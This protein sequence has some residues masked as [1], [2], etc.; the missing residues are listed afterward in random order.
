MN[1]LI[2]RTASFT[3]LLLLTG[4]L[5]AYAQASDCADAQRRFDAALAQQDFK[6]AIRVENEIKDSGSCG[7]QR[8]SF[9]AR[10]ASLQVQVAEAL[11]KNPSR[12]AEREALIIEAD[13]PRLLWTAAYLAG[14][15]Y[16]QKK[17]Y[18][19]AAE[20]LERAIGI[21]GD[22][23]LTPEPPASADQKEIRDLAYAAKTFAAGFVSAGSDRDGNVSGSLSAPRAVEI[24]A[25]P[26]PIQFETNEDVLTP[27][28][29]QYAEELA[30]A[31]KQQNVATVIL[32]GH[33]DPKGTDDYNMDLSKRRAETVAA[34]LKQQ[35]VQA[36]IIT[37][38]KGKRE[39]FSPPDASTL[40]QDQLW[41]LNR[42]VV[43][44]R[45]N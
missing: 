38:A 24:K 5:G 22:K 26:L 21:I 3:A 37:E 23:G 20:A 16:M 32:E 15:L 2:A 36:R 41:A 45:S 30:S 29:K 18:A 34:F 8:G 33:T 17:Q 39:P 44:R 27:V 19:K 14:E 9:R 40:T 6:T 35:G 43:W 4:S 10:R 25:V 13:E 1:G 28:G 7:G 11:R 42:R 12:Q 31:V